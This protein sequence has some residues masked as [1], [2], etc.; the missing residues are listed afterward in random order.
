MDT[1]NKVICP[2]CDG[3]KYIDEDYN[4]ECLF[5]HGTGFVNE[6]E[7]DNIQSSLTFAKV[8]VGVQ[9]KTKYHAKKTF[10]KPFNKFNVI[11]FIKQFNNGTQRFIEGKYKGLCFKHYITDDINVY[12]V[13]K[14]NLSIV[15]H[16]QLTLDF[17]NKI[18]YIKCYSNKICI[19]LDYGYVVLW[20]A[21]KE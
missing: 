18:K 1:M 19:N 17:P 11:S 5:C 14:G 12:L 10:K 21:P 3:K 9:E 6:N 4:H 15:C 7:V 16:K 13:L 2:A 20:Y 8:L